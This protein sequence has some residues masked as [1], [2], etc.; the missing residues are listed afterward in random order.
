M[1]KL[2]YLLFATVLFCSCQ[3]DE[4]F[5]QPVQGGVASGDL[6]EVLYATVADD[7]SVAQ[8]RTYVDGQ[9]V[10]WHSGESISYYAGTYGNVKYTMKEDQPDGT[11]SAEFVKDEDAKYAFGNGAYSEIP[12]YPLAIY[13]Y[14]ETQTATFSQGGYGMQVKFAQEQTY[15]PKSFGKGANIMVAP[16]SSNDDENLFFQHACGYL[17]I[18]LY[19]TGTNVSNITLTALGAGVKLSG[20]ATLRVMQN[21]TV[22][23]KQFADAAHN[24]VM[25][26]CSN[27][28]EGVALGADAEHA[29]EFWFAL[30]PVTI[31][32]GFEITMTDTEG[33]T[34]TK[35]TTKDIEITRRDIQPMAALEF[36]PHLELTPNRFFYTRSDGKTEPITFDDY[37]EDQPFV[38]SYSDWGDL[39]DATIT[40]HYYAEKIGKFVI[41][42]DAPIIGIKDFAFRGSYNNG[43]FLT[44]VSLPSQLKVIG[45]QAFYTNRIQEIVIPSSVTLIK[46]RALR[47]S[48]LNSITFLWSENPLQIRAYDGLLVPEDSGTGAFRDENLEYI[49]IDRNIEYT[50]EDGEEND[51]ISAFLGLFTNRSTCTEVVIGPNMSTIPASMF[52]GVS[53]A[54]LVIPGNITCIGRNN[55]YKSYSL[56]EII[57][58]SSPT[59]TPLTMDGT[60]NIGDTGPFYLQSS[61][62]DKLNTIRLN[63]EINYIL[64]GIDSPNEGV[65]SQ[66]TVL[67][68]LELGPQVKTISDYMFAA[69]QTLTSITIPGSVTS[70][71][72]NAFDECTA[73]T[74]VTFEGSTTNLR[75]GFQDHSSDKGPFYDSPLTYI[76]LNRQIDYIYDDL[77]YADEGVFANVN[78][79]TPA[80]VE[81][82]ENVRAIHNWMFYGVPISSLTIPAGIT[83]IGK[84]AFGNNS[85][86]TT[87]T[88]EGSTP[89]RLNSEPFT[90]T[91][92]QAI[93][94]PSGSIDSY[95]VYWSRYHLNLKE[96]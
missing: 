52:A 69:T 87:I 53:I 54:N 2:I 82:G 44:S 19:G 29:T 95:K 31:T 45:K 59:D 96:Y 76:N 72:N 35:Q 9:D 43:Y 7:D 67:E 66:R 27:G 50:D 90:S 62:G 42:C 61:N 12:D 17:V 73:L 49:Y 77:D 78:T 11:V 36:I 51:D 39:V 75:L 30:P 22:A 25:L 89:A 57:F 24:T 46:D 86:L 91:N 13:P 33:Y 23:F 16:G 80:T 3:K 81:L 84:E 5:E 56:E 26:D 94:V 68:T 37:E 74:S 85:N 10:K 71:G 63:R 83:D 41:E 93:K 58:E 40:K 15:A 65:F 92:L 18:K 8:T 88:C 6:P 64:E 21:Q 20:E 47:A 14:D 60:Y 48:G 70:I 1:K 28:G 4:L 55:F 79:S 34:F 32:G 38:A